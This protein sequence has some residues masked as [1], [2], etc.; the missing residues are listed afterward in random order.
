MLLRTKPSISTDILAAV[1]QWVS[2]FFVSKRRLS[3]F[4]RLIDHRTTY[5]NVFT[6]AFHFTMRLAIQ[7]S[8]PWNKRHLLI[9]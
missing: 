1:I 3:R 8:E 2:L 6:I 5:P 7:P 4:E 9:F